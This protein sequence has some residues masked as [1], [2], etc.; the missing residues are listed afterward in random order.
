M[1]YNVYSNAPASA[2]FLLAKSDFLAYLVSKSQAKDKIL[3]NPLNSL[4][5]LVDKQDMK[6]TLENY[7][8]LFLWALVASMPK[9]V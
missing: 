5:K 4:C 6:K 3:R 2:S 8:V 7:F 1:E 9:F